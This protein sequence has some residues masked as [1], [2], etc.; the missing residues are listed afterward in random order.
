M[1]NDLANAT[2]TT[3]VTMIGKSTNMRPL[4]VPQFQVTIFAGAELKA[5][6]CFLTLYSKKV[7]YCHQNIG[8]VYVCVQFKLNFSL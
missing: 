6:M 1:A 3:T 4:V 7:L 8:L 5:A 2:A